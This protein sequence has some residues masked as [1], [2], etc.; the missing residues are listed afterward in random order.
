MADHNGRM[1]ALAFLQSPI[2]I[3]EALV[4]SG[5]ARGGRLPVPQDAVLDRLAAGTFAP[6]QEGDTVPFGGRTSAWRRVTADKDGWMDAN[7][8][9]F[10]TVD[11]PTA[12]TMSLEAQG[13]SI[14]YVNGSPRGGDPYSTGYVR[15]PVFLGAGRNT[16]LFVAGRGRLKARLLPIVKT[17]TLNTADTTLP[18]VLVTDRADL[19][20]GIVVEN[21]GEARKGLRMRVVLPDGRA[22]E[23]AL[24]RLPSRSVRKVPV[25]LPLPYVI[26]GTSLP[27]TVELRD[28]GRTVDST[29]IE[30]RVRQPNEIH[31]RTFVS[32]VDGSVQYYV[33]NPAQRPGPDNVLALTLH[34]ASVEAQNQAQ[35]YRSKDD[36]TLVA[37]T[38]RRP[39]GFDWE[40]IGRIDALEVLGLADRTLPHDPER[41]VLTGHSMGGHGTWSIGTLYPDRFAAIAPSAGW[42]SFW[43]YAGGWSPE[44]GKPA[45][46]MVRRA[47]EPSDTLARV[48]NTL[49]QGVYILHGDADDNVPVGQARTMKA[50][51]VKLSHP[52]LGYHEEPGAGHWWGDQCV[53]Y[54]DLFAMLRKRRLDSKPAHIDFTTPSPAVSSRAWWA[55]VEAVSEQGLPARIQLDKQN[56]SVEGTTTNVARLTLRR[57]VRTV[58]LDGQSVR[59]TGGPGDVTLV[60]DAGIWHEGKAS[61][62]TPDA[63]GPFKSVFGHKVVF[64]VPTGGST[65]ENAAGLDHARYDAETLYVRGNGGVDILTDAELMK[66]GFERRNV[67]L[68]GNADTNRAWAKLLKGSPVE[69]RRGS[70]RV[71]PRTLTGSDLGVLLVRPK[72][73]TPDC[74]VGAMAPTGSGGAARLVRMATFTSGVAYPDWTVV[75]AKGLVGAGFFGNDWS[76]GTG[77]QGWNP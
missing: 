54:P 74:L 9:V 49:A 5:V 40:E 26:A 45:D 3:R 25:A 29:K 23:S 66:G 71:G 34:G 58:R 57:P 64:V 67:L 21:A 60:R 22:R 55:T 32:D 4:V 18:D 44:P 13:D 50:A 73:G 20:G 19:L 76:L 1:V 11:L 15:L 70:V 17:L 27:L 56:V 36:V 2:E 41:V 53:D 38:N 48:P 14:V 69:V 42:V 28:S 62:K 46:A 7:G 31:R 24:P 52:D 77:A 33:V 6:P 8:Y 35:A 39:Y 37:P 30:L 12:T 65:E 16:L 51:L 72:P 63:M 59:I 68:Y 43:S 10:A 61:G 47:M 75:G